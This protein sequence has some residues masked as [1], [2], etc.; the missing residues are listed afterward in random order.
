MYGYGPVYD[1][2]LTEIRS[3]GID[4]SSMSSQE[5]RWI[6]FKEYDIHCCF[7]DAIQ[8]AIQAAFFADFH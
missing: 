1:N 3:E 6:R 4:I 7:Q 2:N 5:R 8:Q